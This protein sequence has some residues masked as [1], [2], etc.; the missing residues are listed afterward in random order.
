[1]NE[2]RY[3][4]GTE[5]LLLG[6]VVV[7]RFGVLFDVL[8]RNF[9][10]AEIFD[11][12]YGSSLFLIGTSCRPR[13]CRTLISL[14]QCLLDRQYVTAR[15]AIIADFAVKIDSLSKALWAVYVFVFGV[16]QFF[17]SSQIQ[18]VEKQVTSFFI[19]NMEIE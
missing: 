8:C 12:N 14:Q 15:H 18:A 4:S 6:L 9:A 13:N 3:A 7:L 2:G 5:D 1:M 10:G 19:G 17:S 16:K 11:L